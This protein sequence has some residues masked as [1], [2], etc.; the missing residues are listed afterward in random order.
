MNLKKQLQG[1]TCVDI[2][3]SNSHTKSYSKG[4]NGFHY[5]E[6]SWVEI[7]GVMTRYSNSGHEIYINSTLQANFLS[8]INKLETDNWIDRQ[9]RGVIVTSSFVN[10]LSG[11]AVQHYLIFE[12][13][14]GRF[15]TSTYCNLVIPYA[16]NT[17]SLVALPIVGI[18]LATIMLL[19]SIIDLRK[20][21]EQ[22]IKEEAAKLAKQ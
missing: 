15:S 10:R 22:I 8:E 14:L 6:K 20:T 3:S 1:Y 13:V 21:K 19:I 11:M 16:S 12:F 5:K 18:I 17:T 4:A 9:T 7:T 2:F